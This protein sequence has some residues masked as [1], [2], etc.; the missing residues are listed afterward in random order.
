MKT[1]INFFN[2]YR[3]DE[4]NLLVFCILM[5]IFAVPLLLAT[6]PAHAQ[7][8]N[9]YGAG[10]VQIHGTAEE[11][12]VMQ[13]IIR[14]AEPSWQ[15][16]AAGAGVGSAL[17]GFIASNVS[18]NGRQAAGF[19]GLTVGGLLGERATNVMLTNAAQ[20]I[21]LRVAG[22]EGS[23]PRLVTVIQPAPFDPLI[24]G[25]MVYLINTAGRVRVIHQIQ[26]PVAFNH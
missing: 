12:V 2:G 13:V 3:R 16:R 18:G 10:Q 11:A 23:P 24:A 22:R 1:I 21:I 25:E 7:S 20:E 17:G 6:E 15:T 4:R 19:I 26:Q 14:K 9:V 8:G 5:L